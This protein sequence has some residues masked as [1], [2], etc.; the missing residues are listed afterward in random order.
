MYVLTTDGTERRITRYGHTYEE[1]HRKLVELQA[2]HHQGV[3]VSVNNVL[4][5]DYLERWLQSVVSRK[6]PKTY[7]GYRD[8]VRL[9]IT[10]V[11][12]KKRLT[13]L[14]TQDVRRLV[15]HTEQKCICCVQGLD[16]RRIEADRKCCAVGKCCERRLSIRMVQL[17]HAVLRAALQHAVREEL[18][19][20]NVAKLVQV[21]TPDNRLGRGL[22]VAEAHRVLRAAEGEPLSALYVIA[23]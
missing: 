22:S 11:L 19:A 15:A 7:V 4:V 2:Q 6:R 12:G 18:L 14:T 20:R 1:A 8:V 9:H 17:V 21:T 23:L 13:K 5:G 3:P 10:P 16:A